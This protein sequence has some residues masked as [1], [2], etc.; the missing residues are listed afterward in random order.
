M[1]NLSYRINL[2]AHDWGDQTGVLPTINKYDEAD[3]ICLKSMGVD[4]IRLPCNFDIYSE[5]PLGIG[6]IDEDYLKKLDEICDW[7]E[8][9]QIYL[10]IDNHNNK[11][12]DKKTYSASDFTNLQKHLE[13]VWSQIAPRYA[14]RSGT[15]CNVSLPGT[16]SKN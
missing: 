11:T 13:S 8:K 4:V 10:I 12:Y 14:D 1:E 3:F 2:T 6:K 7:A 15:I 9:N 16:A 5:K